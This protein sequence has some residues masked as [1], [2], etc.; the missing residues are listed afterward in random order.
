MPHSD[1]ARAL[2]Q[3]HQAQQTFAELLSHA[4]Q[5]AWDE[6]EAIRQN[7]VSERILFGDKPIPLIL[8]PVVLSRAR[9]RHLRQ[10]MADLNRLLTRLEP[11]MHQSRWL[12]WLGF[13]PAEQEWIQLPQQL[14]SG[15][16][17]SRVDG[18]LSENPHTPHDYK[19]VELNIDS[20]GGGAFL[21]VGSRVVQDSELWQA[22]AQRA[23]GRT[24]PFSES[25]F[26]HLETVWASHLEDHPQISSASG[27]PRI[28][29]VDWITVSTHREFELLAEGLRLRGFDTLVADPRELQ[30][31]SG[32]LRDY[33]GKPIDL[34][35]R[36][37]LV[38]DMLR[39]PG[40]S[41]ALVEACR[42]Q[43]VC[44]VNSFASKPL[45]VKSLLALFHD[46]E[47][48]E[49]LQESE[50]RLVDDLI[51]VTLR[52]TPEN[53]E[54]V[55]RDKDNFVLKPADGWGAQGLYLGW[56]CRRDEWDAHLKRSQAIGGYV[57]QERVDI[58]SRSLPTWTGQQWESFPYMFDLSPYGLAEHAVSPL[59]R[60]S[61]SEVLNVKQG[62]RIAAVWVLDQGTPS[63]TEEC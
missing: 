41:R 6:I 7:L 18:F 37:V 34:V 22:F 24:I 13:R 50:R 15:L 60:L 29:I 1:G 42:H 19:V 33:D 17:I 55:R 8:A 45:T 51:P 63:A 32:R 16:S 53:I 5:Q 35:Y 2:A 3:E 58:P 27:K 46:P 49:L 48:R 26:D 12:D 10:Q 4:P 57:A 28:A 14:R 52:L 36:R 40:G 44:M 59:V 62:A 23:P 30:F 43:A 11:L 21:D 38:E 39:D 25:L 9:W 61:P 47:G 31:S 56:R 20:P 54:L